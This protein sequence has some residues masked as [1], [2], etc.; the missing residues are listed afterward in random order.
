[1]WI[2]FRVGEVGLALGLILTVIVLLSKE[3]DRV[4]M[5]R[6]AIVMCFLTAG[7]FMLIS[8]LLP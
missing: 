3:S 4:Q 2:L 5:L 1:M 7:V 6:I 8:Q